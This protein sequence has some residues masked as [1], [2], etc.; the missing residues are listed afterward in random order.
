M[1][2][3]RKSRFI[4]NAELSKA[5]L[6]DIPYD[7]ALRR[8]FVRG[9]QNYNILQNPVYRNAFGITDEFARTHKRIRSITLPSHRG[10]SALEATSDIH[11]NCGNTAGALGRGIMDEALTALALAEVETAAPSKPLTSVLGSGILWNGDSTAASRVRRNNE[12]VTPNGAESGGLV[13]TLAAAEADIGLD[14]AGDGFGSTVL[15]KSLLDL[16]RDPADVVAYRKMK[17]FESER[18]LAPSVAPPSPSSNPPSSIHT[19]SLAMASGVGGPPPNPYRKNLGDGDV[20]RKVLVPKATNSPMRRD[21]DSKATPVTGLGGTKLPLPSLVA[22][23][24]N[25]E[26]NVGAGRVR[27]PLEVNTHL[28]PPPPSRGSPSIG[29]GRKSTSGV[30]SLPL[31]AN[32]PFF[33]PAVPF[34]RAVKPLVDVKPSATSLSPA[35]ALDAPHSFSDKNKSNSTTR[36]QRIHE[37]ESS[38]PLALENSLNDFHIKPLLKSAIAESPKPR[39]LVNADIPDDCSARGTDAG[40]VGP[41]P[42]PNVLDVFDAAPENLQLKV[43]SSSDSNGG[44]VDEYWI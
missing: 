39:L 2:W 9:L 40:T 18:Q 13:G 34:S 43:V 1:R 6:Q 17:R 42:N 8:G 21:V 7:R 10:L 19:H 28:P 3:N 27:L 11:F 23:I 12:S 37:S 20:D 44:E 38:G 15:T 36:N 32:I 33:D 14:G 30:D 41:E 4:K 35:L 24:A 31:G 16:R 26:P 29:G 5:K 22:N 25:A